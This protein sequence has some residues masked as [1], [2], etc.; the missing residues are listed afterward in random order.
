[1]LHV[2]QNSLMVP[3]YN[4]GLACRLNEYLGLKMY[5]KY[6][7]KLVLEYPCLLSSELILQ[8]S[9]NASNRFW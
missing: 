5:T 7:N 9:L 2:V 3:S 1:M 8:Y 6:T 4:T